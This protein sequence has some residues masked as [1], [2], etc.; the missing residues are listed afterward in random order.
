MLLQLRKLKFN[1]QIKS[2]YKTNKNKNQINK[3]IILNQSHLKVKV[4]PNQNLLRKNSA[5]IKNH[6]L[7][8]RAALRVLNNRNPYRKNSYL[9]KKSSKTVI[10]HMINTLKMNM[11][12]FQIKY[13]MMNLQKFRVKRKLQRIKLNFNSKNK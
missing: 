9:K 3:I 13:L 5:V 7:L 12:H 6:H 10:H 8:L 2:M 1:N 11:N 4:N